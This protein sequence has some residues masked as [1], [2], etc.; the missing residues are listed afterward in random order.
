MGQRWRW[1]SWRAE[2]NNF[3][4]LVAPV[5]FERSGALLQD[6]LPLERRNE[7]EHHTRFDHGDALRFGAALEKHTRFQFRF[8]RLRLESF[9][10]SDL[11]LTIALSC[12]VCS[13]TQ[14]W[15]K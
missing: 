9:L 3:V 4:L 10:E 5:C 6:A 11:P 12:H 13:E 7:S 8:E 14:M 15:F 1:R 2:L